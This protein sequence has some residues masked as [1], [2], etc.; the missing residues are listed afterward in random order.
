MLKYNSTQ[1][2]EAQIQLAI[3]DYLALKKLFFW[4]QNT[5][6]VYD[7]KAG[8]HRPMP[9]Y[10]MNGVPDIIVIK[11]GQFIGLEVK[12]PKSKPSDHQL[13]F[14]KQ[15]ILNKAEYYIV[16]SIDDVMKIL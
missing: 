2:K 6:G 8:F 7:A 1:P 3:C 11:N 15:C 12:R 10:S 16:R 13:E 4:R 14:Q 5:G 9:K